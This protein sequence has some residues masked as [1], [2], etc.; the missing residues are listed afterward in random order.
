MTV[1]AD[2]QYGSTTLLATLRKDDPHSLRYSAISQGGRSQWAP[3]GLMDQALKTG[4]S[5]AEASLGKSVWAYLSSPEGAVEGDA[6]A[7][8][9][10][11]AFSAVDVAAAERLDT[12]A[13]GEPRLT[14]AVRRA[15]FYG[16]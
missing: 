16:R 9:M 15:R 1:E 2:G 3:W 10:G 7:K 4:A 11:G 14:S 13:I 8:L 5:Q 6:V 12:R